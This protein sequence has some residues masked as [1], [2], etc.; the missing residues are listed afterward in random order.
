M[1]KWTD[2]LYITHSEWVESFGGAT[3]NS[4]VKKNSSGFRRLPFYC[5]SLSLSPF[6]NPV[7]TNEGIIFELIYIIPYVK[8]HGN[9]PV[10]GQKLELKSLFKLKFYKNADGEYHCPI[11]LKTF[12]EHSHIVVN[13]VTGIVYSF[14][15]IQKMNIEAKNMKD[16]ITDEPFSKQDLITIQDPINVEFRDLSKFH[17]L[18]ENIKAK[19]STQTVEDLSKQIGKDAEEMQEVEVK[20]EQRKETIMTKPYNASLYSTGRA[21]ASLTS[22]IMTPVTVNEYKIL[23]EDEYLIQNV[24]QGEK[25]FVSINTNYGSLN[26]ELLCEKAPRACLNF[27]MLCKQGYYDNCK[28]HRL[29]PNFMVQGGD[30]SGTGRGGSS[31]WKK[32]FKDEVNHLSHDQRGLL[33]M[34][35]KGKDTNTSQFFITFQACKHLDY[36]HTIFGKVVG[37]MNVL[38]EIEKIPSDKNHTPLKDIIIMST[39]VFLDPFEKARE[40]LQRERLKGKELDEEGKELPVEKQQPKRKVDATLPDFDSSGSSSIAPAASVKKGAFGNFSSW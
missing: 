19:A 3:A 38:N 26:L 17:F 24:K 28:F 23:D 40:K 25:G 1:G 15:A 18:K 13:R 20:T 7:C 31:Y 14:E 11:M 5:C 35:N 12:N 16:L 22:T 29:I 10:T 39:K 32:A 36:K 21:A 8:K 27:L 37:G 4:K 9:N 30:P 2:K 34:A 33:S 6:S